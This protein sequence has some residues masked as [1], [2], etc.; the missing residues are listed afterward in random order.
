M[1][2]SISLEPAFLW[3]FFIK[4][5][6]FWEKVEGEKSYEIVILGNIGKG[7]Y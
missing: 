4:K 2:V 1:Q 5:N 3:E 6:H 7:N